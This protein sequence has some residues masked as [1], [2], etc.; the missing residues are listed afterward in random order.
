MMDGVLLYNR[1][2]KSLRKLL[3]LTTS[4]SSPSNQTSADLHYPL[5]S[6]KGGGGFVEPRGLASMQPKGRQAAYGAPG[7]LESGWHSSALGRP[8]GNPYPDQLTSKPGPNGFA[9]HFRSRL[10]NLNDLKETAL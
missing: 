6:S 2:L 10:P 5:P 4:S 8:E 1:P 3:H 7:P 9:R